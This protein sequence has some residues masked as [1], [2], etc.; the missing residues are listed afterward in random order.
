M[1]NPALNDKVFQEAAVTGADPGWAAP[2]AEDGHLPTHRSPMV[3][4]APTAATARRHDRQRHRRRHRV[5]LVLLI[6]AGA[7][8]WNS[9]QRRCQQPDR[10]L[11]RLDP[12]ALFGALGVAFLTVFKPTWPSSWARCTPSSKGSWWGPSPHVYNAQWDGIVIRPSAPPWPSFAVMLAL[13]GLRII[14]SPTGSAASSSAPPSA[15]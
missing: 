4:P 15:S 12:A 9:R 3:R 8:G 1:P 10:Q 2:G 14:T 6:V 5:L 13:Y 11:P 7:F